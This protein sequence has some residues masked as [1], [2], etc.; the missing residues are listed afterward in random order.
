M[1]LGCRSSGRENLGMAFN[2]RGEVC[3][4]N[5]GKKHSFVPILAEKL[6]DREVVLV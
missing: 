1:T 4:E 6:V 2:G 5:R 3:L